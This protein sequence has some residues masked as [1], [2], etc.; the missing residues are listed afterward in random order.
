MLKAIR[1]SVLVLTLFGS[2]YAGDIQNGLHPNPSPT[3][4]TVED[5]GEEPNEGSA[6]EVQESPVTT[7]EL[8]LNLMQIVLALF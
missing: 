7:T 6:G 3:P 4:A 5:I 8:T 1:A 2:V